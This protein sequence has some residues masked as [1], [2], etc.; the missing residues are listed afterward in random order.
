[1]EH[2]IKLNKQKKF[3]GQNGH[4]VSNQTKHLTMLNKQK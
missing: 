4:W 1:M 3:F 2:L